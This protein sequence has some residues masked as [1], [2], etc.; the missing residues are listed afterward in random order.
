MC[1][2]STPSVAT[3]LPASSSVARRVELGP[4]DICSL[5]IPGHNMVID[6]IRKLRRTSRNFHGSCGVCF[7]LYRQAWQFYINLR[8]I[9]AT[10]LIIIPNI[11][12]RS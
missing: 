1:L 11:V 4:C 8:T 6:Y 7:A 5:G 3:G 12:L 9:A 2:Y 10:W